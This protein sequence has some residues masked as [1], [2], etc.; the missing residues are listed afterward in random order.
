[1]KKTIFTVGMIFLLASAWPD[2]RRYLRMR[3][4]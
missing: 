4:M 2:I 3:M 1:M